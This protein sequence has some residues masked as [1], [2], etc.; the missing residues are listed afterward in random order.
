MSNR[1]ISRGIK[2]VA[3]LE[4]GKAAV[5][6]VAGLGILSLIHRDLHAIATHLVAGLHLNP[7][8][9]YPRIFIDAAD[10][11]TDAR[12][13]TLA[14]LAMI[15]ALCRGI[16]AYGLW[17]ERAWAEWFA[18]VTGAIYLPFEIYE[19]YQ[20]VNGFKVVAVIVNLVIVAWLTFVLIHSR[21]ETFGGQAK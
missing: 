11:L 5:V 9:K 1:L 18:L 14:G 17:R 10:K 16:E 8:K 12:L 2:T 6:V 21:R 15:Y 7:A 20:G 4:A 19:L 3:L 13:W